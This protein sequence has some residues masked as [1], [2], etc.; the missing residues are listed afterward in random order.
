ML[1]TYDPVKCLVGDSMTPLQAAAG[2]E[3]QGQGEGTQVPDT[4]YKEVNLGVACCPG[5]EHFL[6]S[7][8]LGT[9]LASSQCRPCLFIK[10]TMNLTPEEFDACGGFAP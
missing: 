1:T 7:F 4:D 2:C 10:S 6:K 8:L 3:G 9:L 5:R